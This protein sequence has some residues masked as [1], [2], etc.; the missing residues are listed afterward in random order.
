MGA[1]R[2]DAFR[3]APRHHSRCLGLLAALFAFTALA[4]RPALR[5]GATPPQGLRLTGCS[6][7]PEAVSRGRVFELAP[8]GRGPQVLWVGLVGAAEP[9]LVFAWF[10]QG[11]PTKARCVDAGLID[12]WAL[13]LSTLPSLPLVRASQSLRGECY[14]VSRT[15]VLAWTH[16]AGDFELVSSR[17]SASP[18]VACAEASL[19]QEPE[20]G[21]LSRAEALMAEGSP[22]DAERLILG[23]VGERPWDP[24]ARVALAQAWR[25]LNSAGRR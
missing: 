12:P 21:R 18:R 23:L 4:E 14:S 2:T 6:L 3:Y 24:M 22:H 8:E 1:L 20:D 9:H 16:G 11:R 5:G 19:A 15:V 10:P 17:T 25:A 13:E 7:N